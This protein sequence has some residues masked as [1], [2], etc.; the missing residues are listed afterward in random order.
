MCIAPRH[1][2]LVRCGS[3]VMF[4]N[5]GQRYRLQQSRLVNFEEIKGNNSI[6]LGGNQSRSG[7]VFLNVEGFHLQSGVI[8]NTKPQPGENLNTSRNLIQ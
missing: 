2:R 3:V 7:R 6:L 8:V 5:V 1:L 4:S